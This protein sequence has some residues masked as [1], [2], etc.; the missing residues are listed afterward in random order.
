MVL[1]S[2]ID[3]RANRHAHEPSHMQKA[4]VFRSIC[5]GQSLFYNPFDLAL[6]LRHANDNVSPEYRRK[7]LVK[8]TPES[9]QRKL[10]PSVYAYPDDEDPTYG[11]AKWEES[12]IILFHKSRPPTLVG[13]I[14]K[15]INI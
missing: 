4:L 13:A 3:V 14:A 9:A 11:A 2:V 15:H 10:A 5:F 1:A 12:F 7:V 8:C 6:I